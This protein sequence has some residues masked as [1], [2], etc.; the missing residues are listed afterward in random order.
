[1]AG[2][3]RKFKFHGAFKTK[4]RAKHKERSEACHGHCFILKRMVRGV[5]RF[6][7]LERR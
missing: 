3:G 1:M 6:M 2:K 7:V 4:A 5:S